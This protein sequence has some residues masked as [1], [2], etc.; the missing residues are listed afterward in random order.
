MCKYPQIHPLHILVVSGTPSIHLFSKYSV[1]QPHGVNIVIP[2]YASPFFTQS[3]LA[4]ICSSHFKN[5]HFVIL[6]D[7]AIVTI[8]AQILKMHMTWHTF[9]YSLVPSIRLH[10]PTLPACLEGKTHT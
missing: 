3:I 8:V 1:N 5:P 9:S 7:Y 6:I 4:E 2:V 10:S